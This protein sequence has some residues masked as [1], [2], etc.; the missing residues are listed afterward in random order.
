MALVG[1]DAE[2]GE[3]EIELELG[4]DEGSGQDLEAEDAAAEGVEELRRQGRSDSRIEG[5]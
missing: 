4:D 3:D 2:L 1:L 5:S